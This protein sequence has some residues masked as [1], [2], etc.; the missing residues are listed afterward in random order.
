[1][2][3]AV[4]KIFE[5]H[6]PSFSLLST[7]LDGTD[8]DTPRKNL[9]CGSHVTL[10]W[11][12]RLPSQATSKLGAKLLGACSW[13]WPIFYLRS[14]WQ[15]CASTG[16]PP[17]DRMSQNRRLVGSLGWTW[18]LLLP[19]TTCRALSRHVPSSHPRRSGPQ[20]TSSLSWTWLTRWASQ[21][22]CVPNPRSCVL[23]SEVF[24]ELSPMFNTCSSNRLM[25]LDGNVWRW[26][27]R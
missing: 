19:T 17:V 22:S 26:F 5:R 3:A 9:V 4:A 8:M 18:C 21:T 27:R 23:F 6:F 13:S 1:M 14:K 16:A 10:I 2:V 24:C 11:M 20:S 15:R 25:M 12:L 7:A